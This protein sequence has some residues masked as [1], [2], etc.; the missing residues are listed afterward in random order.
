MPPTRNGV[1]RTL[2]ESPW[3]TDVH[4]CGCN[5][6]FYFASHPHFIKFEELWRFKAKALSNTVLSRTGCSV[7]MTLP[8]LLKLYD[9]VET[10]GFY[11]E[12]EGVPVWQ[13][14]NLEFDGP[15]LKTRAFAAP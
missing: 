1:F 13:R 8:A 5:V 4:A 11:I 2:S 15:A 14:E 3:H 12:V 9:Q 7:D 10:F 6:R